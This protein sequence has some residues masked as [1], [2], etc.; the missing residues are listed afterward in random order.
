MNPEQSKHGLDSPV[1]KVWSQAIAQNSSG[2]EDQERS[3]FLEALEQPTPETRAAFIAHACAGNASLRGAVEAL[4][5]HHETDDFLETPAIEAGRLR[6]LK[7]LAD[8]EN[9]LGGCLEKVGD[10]IGHYK[11]LQRIG[12]GGC[13][14][15]YMAEQ[16]QPIRR[17]VALKIIKLG[18]DTKQVIAR[19]EAERQALAMMEHPNIAKVLDAGATETGR[20][21]FVMELVR[22]IKIT[23]HC[24]QNELSTEERLRLFVAVCH[25]V[26]HAHQKG[27]I[28]RDLKPSNVLVTLHD[29]V[30][31]PKVIDF[32]IAKATGQALTDKTV[33]TDFHAFIG[34]PAYTSP[35]QAE[36][37]GLDVDT[38]SDIYSLGVLLYELITGQTPFDPATLMRCNLDEMR[39]IIRE[40]EPE[41]PSTRLSTLGMAEATALCRTRQA[42][43]PFLMDAV[44]G[45]LDWIVMK[46]LEKD[47]NRRYETADALAT[48]ILR[49]LGNEPV[50]A[51][52]PSAVYQISKFVRRNRSK[53]YAGSII[54]LVVLMAA[55]ISTGLAI[56]ATQA[57]REQS[58]LRRGIE[59]AFKNETRQRQKAQREQIAALRRA[60]N[61][62]MNLVQQAL[63]ANNLGRVIDLLD[64]QRPESQSTTEESPALSHSDFVGQPDFRQWEWRYFWNQS[65]SQAA[66][67][68][69]QQDSSVHTLML[70]P[71]GTLLASDAGRG[72]LRLWD[73][74]ARKE[75][76]LLP[77]DGFT[78][79]SLAFSHDGRLLALTRRQGPQSVVI[80]IRTT[81]W[82]PDGEFPHNGAVQ[83][84]AFK[85]DNKSM[86]TFGQD[87]VV[88]TWGLEKH[89]LISETPAPSNLGRG[90]GPNRA[91][92]SRDGAWL[93]VLDR[94]RIRVTD[95]ST[96]QERCRTERLPSGVAG[97][98][99]SPGGKFLA[100]GPSFSG[101]NT[102]I[103]LFSGETG[104]P[105]GDLFGHTSW[106]PS[107]AFTA[108]G[109]KL[110]SAGAD[111]SIRIWDVS[112]HQELA[113][114]R[115]H[116]SE[117]YA[118]TVNALGS[119]AVSG[120][121]DGSIY[122]WDLNHI[123]RRPA[124]DLLPTGVSSV[125][126]SAD[127]QRLYSVNADGS[128]FLWDPLN[129]RQIE[130]INSLGRRV[131]RLLASPDNTRL[132]AST[133]SGEIEVLDWS[134]RQ[135]ITNFPASTESTPPFGSG[136]ESV[137]LA[138]VNGGR[139]LV[140]Q[141]SD[142]WIRLFD[143][144]SWRPIGQWKNEDGPSPP[145][146]R[147]ISQVTP[148]GGTLIASR[149]RGE[150]ETFDLLTGRTRQSI[151]GSGRRVSALALSPDG[152]LLAAA[153]GDGSVNMWDWRES[154]RP[155]VL[156]GTL[157]NIEAVAFSPDGQRLA[158]SSH[159][160]EAVKL[161]DVA[162]R[163][164]VATLP[165]EGSLFRQ[166]LFS[167]DGQLLVAVNIEGQAHVWRAPALEAIDQMRN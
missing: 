22:G 141:A 75:V 152:L 102:A 94:D 83:A 12:E 84:S 18:M 166:V 156:R 91:I 87:G 38:R 127:S 163:H 120:C 56:R 7:P 132:Y 72:R 103:L 37:S 145:G 100:A 104:K 159:G 138:L 43:L 112:N 31:V 17:R 47:R 65:R 165:G 70:S 27:I 123:Y 36:M 62:D 3:L 137:S 149:S 42:R 8:E 126:F 160:N 35:E 117:I 44:R 64:R 119:Q 5:A 68:L 110:V 23:E 134:T 124:F 148:D 113:A 158:T 114:L 55:V 146:A 133:R 93:A 130:A 122:G 71:D 78:G 99:L 1:S 85:A 26:Q 82:Q 116:R 79:G 57:E 98:D 52:P 153:S 121:K 34:T 73:L 9:A 4:L 161:W 14:I 13:G 142:G 39:R 49:Y 131:N 129:L 97:L 15:V 150:I 86:V 30:P 80:L 50:S 51:R 125:T 147:T 45:D 128:V 111:Q 162:T 66:F 81:T 11:L 144:V 157:L 32:G 21:Y 2:P 164:E 61:S 115:G 154:T 20:P 33:F 40:Q 24:D 139:T 96:G 74:S 54:A 46:C 88:R 106:V 59:L 19:F 28:H 41:R 101:T 10:C 77:Y 89:D 151:P 25:A 6:S 90:F 92:F 140:V 108:D 95:A 118:V 69:P 167:P 67:S 143:T 58:R 136:R 53:V 63:G 16:H 155:D 48:D 76:A 107:L 105:A 109:T 135:T 29:G 60:Y